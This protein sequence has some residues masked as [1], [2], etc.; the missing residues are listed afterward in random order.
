MGLHFVYI[1]DK[2][3]KTKRSFSMKKIIA[4]LLVLSTLLSLTACGGKKEEPA[5][6]TP[7]EV[8][9][10][11]TPTPV[12]DMTPHVIEGKQAFW[13]QIFKK[14]TIQT[15]SDSFVLKAGDL[16]VS[17]Q[18]DANDNIFI[19]Y[20]FNQKTKNI[21]CALYISKNQDGF[22]RVYDTKTGIDTWD[23]LTFETERDKNAYKTLLH[24]MQKEFSLVEDVFDTIDRIE[25]VHTINNRDYIT[26]YDIQIDKT[27]SPAVIPTEGASIRE[28]AL[29]EYA[30]DNETF[31]FVYLE[32]N[33]QGDIQEKL[34]F[35]GKEPSGRYTYDAA[36][37]MI[38]VK[39][40]KYRC[41]KVVDYPKQEFPTVE[42]AIKLIMD[43][44]TQS[45]YSIEFEE[46]GASVVYEF[47]KCD[48]AYDI[49]DLP[50]FTEDNMP[51]TEAVDLF[52]EEARTALRHTLY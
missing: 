30:V 2:K 28:Y 48:Q 18:Q 49:L 37:H 10:A 25:Y 47:T 17:A 24:D 19:G 13:D 35:V 32:E 3:F 1:I 45:I 5:A 31:Q 27:K 4:L 6:E 51:L 11:T 14:S 42:I 23:A 7:T 40:T 9:E 15:A 29:Y 21:P 50:F 34:C 39:G 22:F 12:V 20:Y 33:Y 16:V 36:N 43:P 46:N 41:S 44:K 38:D 26:A 52:N 8:T